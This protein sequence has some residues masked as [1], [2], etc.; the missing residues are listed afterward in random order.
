MCVSVCVGVYASCVSVST[1]LF[2]SVILLKCLSVG[3]DVCGCIEVCVFVV[4]L[5]VCTCVHV[6]VCV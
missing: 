6:C 1:C 2:M 4:S 5:C 3:I